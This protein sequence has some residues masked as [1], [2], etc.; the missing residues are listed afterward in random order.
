MRTEIARLIG[1][2]V[3]RFCASWKRAPALSLSKGDAVHGLQ[4]LAL[5]NVRYDERCFLP[6]HICEGTSG[7]RVAVILRTGKTPTG[8]EV[9]TVLK[10]VITRIRRHWPKVHIL[11]RGD[12]H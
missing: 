1:A 9:R 8:A 4:Q 3:D 6:N 5:F 7:K 11:V 2:M 12:S 10:H